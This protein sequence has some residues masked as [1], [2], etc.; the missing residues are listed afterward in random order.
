MAVPFCENQVGGF[1]LIVALS[2][3]WQRKN[4]PGGVY[5]AAPQRLYQNRYDVCGSCEAT[6]EN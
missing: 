2:E 5:G 1:S 4:L 3:V 6:D